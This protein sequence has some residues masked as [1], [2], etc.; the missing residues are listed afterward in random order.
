MSGPYSDSLYSLDFF[1]H[2]LSAVRLLSLTHS[3]ADLAVAENSPREVGGDAPGML[4]V[5]RYLL[6]ERRATAA[7]F[8]LILKAGPPR[9]LTDRVTG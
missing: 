1:S 2:S 3:N 6:A 4:P 5:P 9:E 7:E 8:L